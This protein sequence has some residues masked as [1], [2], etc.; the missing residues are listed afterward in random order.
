[1][2]GLGFHA[3]LTEVAVNK[4]RD[5][6]IYVRS[7]Y[8]LLAFELGVIRIALARSLDDIDCPAASMNSASLS[9]SN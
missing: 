6:C 9:P 2:T 4:Q 3:A 1:M 8:Q 7:I 5:F